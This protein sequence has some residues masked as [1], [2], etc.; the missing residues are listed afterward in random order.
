MKKQMLKQLELESKKALDG[1][2]FHLKNGDKYNLSTFFNGKRSQIRSIR[3]IVKKLS[4]NSIRT[5]DLPYFVEEVFFKNWLK[6]NKYVKS[7]EPFLYTKN[8][9]KYSE[10]ILFKVF[11]NFLE[12]GN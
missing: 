5:V 2:K 7:K 11:I 8:D 9:T 4:S 12:S 6:E 3:K 1:Y 10:L